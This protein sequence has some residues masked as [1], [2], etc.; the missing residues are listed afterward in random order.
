ME[1]TKDLEQLFDVNK[2]I[3]TAEKNVLSVLSYVQPTEVSNTLSKL[4]V[5]HGNFARANLEALKGITAVAKA[6]TEEFT[7]SLTKVAK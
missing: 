3:D 4:V 5:A 1:F 7:K 6:S 2:A